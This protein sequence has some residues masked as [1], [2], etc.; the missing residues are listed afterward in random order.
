MS[1]ERV[2]VEI[3]NLEQAL[4]L[5]E[6]VR[7]GYC[8]PIAENLVAWIAVEEDLASSYEKLSEK[9][10]Q[11]E[12][13]S[14]MKE[15]REESKNNIIVLHEILKSIE[16]LGEERDQRRQLIEKLISSKSG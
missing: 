11:Q 5:E 4:K 12:I 16:Q 2:I 6:T 10:P 3:E 7:T 1:R 13:K 14:A 8:D 9:Y 15:L